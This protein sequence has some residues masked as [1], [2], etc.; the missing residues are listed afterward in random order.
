METLVRKPQTG[1]N[2]ILLAAMLVAAMLV[3]AVVAFFALQPT[4]Q[5]IEQTSMEGAVREGAP[6]F[7]VL[8]K[9][10]AISND[11]KNTM[12][13]PTGLGTIVMNIAGRIRNMTGK[14]L[15]GLEIRVAVVDQLNNPVKEKTLVV[16]PTQ[17]E[18]LEP[19]ETM[20]VRVMM[21]GFS[22]EDDRAMIR[23]VVTAIKVKE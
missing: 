20:P 17:K 7:E 10:I 8:T 13:S 3:A 19:N 11:E 1:N 22:K 23:W 2:K 9:R 16:V 21:E 15:T 4:K 14:T 18:R 6:E 12:Q 5:Q